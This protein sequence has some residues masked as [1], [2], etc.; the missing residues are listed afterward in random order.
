MD[1]SPV[2]VPKPKGIVVLGP[3][4]VACGSYEVFRRQMACC[5]ELGLKTY[6]LAVAPTFGIRNNSDYWESYY[7]Y[8]TNL[9]ADYRGHVGRSENI[10][11]HTELVT[12][13][14]PGVFR[15]VPFWDSVRSRFMVVPDDLKDFIARHDISTVICHHFF[16]MPLAKRIRRL[17]PGAQLILETQDVQT[18]HYLSRQERHPIW[19]RRASERAMLRDEMRMSGGAD[20]LVHYNDREAVTFKKHLPRKRHITVYPAFPRNYKLPLMEDKNKTYDFVIVASANDPNYNS[21][22]TFLEQVWVPALDGKRTLRIL[23][24]I[25]WLFRKYHDPLIERFPEIFVGLVHDLTPWYQLARYVVLPVVEG[26]GIAIKTIEALSFGKKVVAMPLAYRGFEDQVP[27]DLTAEVVKTPQQFQE[28]LLSFDMS[29]Y[30]E[31]D[32]RTIGLYEKLFTTDRQTAIYRELLT[33]K[34]LV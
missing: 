29:G 14:V 20:V 12:D 19:R 5:R 24:N 2:T 18:N 32:P 27:A 3:A 25:D 8:T 11:K 31:Q 16:N 10:L 30:A 13:I 4:W 6:F 17:V 34:Q 28:R 7:R 1:C 26:Q 23:G 15:S 22:K 21:V 9:G 33:P